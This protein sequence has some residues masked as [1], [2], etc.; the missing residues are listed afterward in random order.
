MTNEMSNIVYY[1]PLLD[2]IDNF[3]KHPIVS[4][5]TSNNSE[6]IIK[7]GIKE[8][9]ENTDY[10][11]TYKNGVSSKLV[12]Y[13]GRIKRLNEEVYPIVLSEIT[14]YGLDE[15]NVLR[16]YG[17][18]SNS[19]KGDS[20]Q[21]VLEKD[22]DIEFLSLDKV[23][24][25]KRVILLVGIGR[26]GWD[27]KSLTGVILSQEND[28]NKKN[29]LQTCCRTLRQVKKGDNEK[30]IIVL[31]K[32]NADKF[33]EQ[34][35]NECNTNINEIQS[36]NEKKQV[37]YRYDRREFVDLCE[38]DFSYK[39]LEL[40]T[41]D[42]ILIKT[43]TKKSINESIKTN[44]EV[45]NR[46]K[47]IKTNEEYGVDTEYI[48]GNKKI[49]SY[50]I[51]INDIVKTSFNLISYQN[52]VSEYNE[53][54]INLYNKIIDCDKGCNFIK[55]NIDYEKTLENIRKS[56]SDIYESKKEEI[57]IKRDA[58]LLIADKLKSIEDVSNI[59]DYYPT[60]D[61][62]EKVHK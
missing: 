38:P 2:G 26:E 60:Q 13:C 4:I 15:T 3:L 50:N 9:F 29:V 54:L 10:N 32:F 17:N 62:V 40:K 41:I 12:I 23:Y 56:F 6:Y 51:F 39:D 22:A 16:Y 1:Y 59:I 31:N 55:K 33:N 48:I 24:S 21:Y 18:T 35:E 43:D 20:K 61:I 42:E 53:D 45:L 25:K 57:Y 30:A 37:I 36:K 19:E 52:L 46:K 28:S 7:K 11:K 8:F 58:N 44:E 27:C 49:I 14:K 34:L 47:D 5:S